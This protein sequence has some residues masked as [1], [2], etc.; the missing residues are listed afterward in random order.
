MLVVESLEASKAVENCMCDAAMR[1][2][3]WTIPKRSGN[4]A[5]LY[6][7]GRAETHAKVEASGRV[8]CKSHS[9]ANTVTPS[10]AKDVT[11]RPPFG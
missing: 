10:Q 8:R 7:V 6:S 9:R 3:H 2:R 5:V 1:G 11:M 4:A